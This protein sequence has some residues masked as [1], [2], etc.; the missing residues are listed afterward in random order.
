M[1][2]LNHQ[3]R[4]VKGRFL[5]AFVQPHPALRS[6]LSAPR[7]PPVHLPSEVW[8]RILDYVLDDTR[9][10]AEAWNL[11]LVNKEL[12]VCRVLTF[13]RSKH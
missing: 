9:E 3:S 4:N 7:K 1:I 10:T 5:N 13:P 6:P 2:I 8:A 11:L 12:K